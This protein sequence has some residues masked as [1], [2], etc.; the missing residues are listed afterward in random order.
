WG[1]LQAQ[2]ER[3]QSA[4]QRPVRLCRLSQRAGASSPVDRRDGV[5]EPGPLQRTA[6][7][8]P[9]RRVRGARAV[10]RRPQTVRSHSRYKDLINV[11]RLKLVLL[12]TCFYYLHRKLM[13]AKQKVRV[14]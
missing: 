1:L 11:I 13:Q 4:G 10:G 8:W 6:A 7:R 5:R 3:G 14:Q 9:L 12:F 2:R